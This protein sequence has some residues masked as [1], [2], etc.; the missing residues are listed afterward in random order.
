MTRSIVERMN[1]TGQLLD[2]AGPPP[3]SSARS[4]SSASGSRRPPRCWASRRRSSSAAAAD[5]ACRTAGCRRRPVVE[6]DLRFRRRIASPAFAFPVPCPYNR[7]RSIRHPRGA[8]ATRHGPSNS[9]AKTD[10]RPQRPQPQSARHARAARSMAARRCK[11]VEKLCRET[12]KR[13]RARGRVPPVQPR[14]RADRLD[15]GGRRQEGRRHRHQSR[16]P[17][18]TPRSRSTTRSRRS[19][20]P[21]IEVHITNIFARESFRHHLL[22]LAGR[23]GHDL[24]LRHRRLC[25]RDRRA[26]RD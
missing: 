1:L 11:D 17:T 26:C 3:S 4:T 22:R 7:R 14:G 15:P 16:R 21:V 8:G 6:R 24:R 25:A 13:A 5:A 9:M 18:P 10:L 2:L 19:S 20:V 12:G 23:Q